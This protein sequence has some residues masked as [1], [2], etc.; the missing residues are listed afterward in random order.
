MTLRDMRG[1]SVAAVI[2]ILAV[3]T[4][5]GVIFTSLFTTGVE[6]STGEVLS[7]R[8]LYAAEAGV[9][10]AIG[11]LK[12]N[13]VSTNWSWHDGY[14]DKAVG[15]GSFD[16]EVLQ[17][18][19]R[20]STLAAAFACEPF[21]STIDP[22][23]ANPARTVYVVL[24]WA[25]AGNMGVELY[26]NAVADC[27]NPAAS[28]NLISSSLTSG[29]PEKIRYRISAAAPPPLTYTVRVVGT[30]GDAYNLRIAHPEESAFG[31]GNTCGAPAG[32]PYDEC[33]RAVISLGK[34][35]KARREV[36]A[37]MSRTP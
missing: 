21:E 10:T 31:T 2:L 25:G 15:S 9:E 3:L 22:A 27:S 18:E 16:V 19:E 4:A 23:A 14:L 32:P 37:A 8:A 26:D 24:S 30:A 33:M 29:K 13:P 1:A 35:E 34:H 12:I 7:T 28:A 5:I 17:Y 11:R 6:E 20:D 36:F